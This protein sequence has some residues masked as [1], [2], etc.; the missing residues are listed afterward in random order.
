M[1][2]SSGLI[3]LRRQDVFYNMFETYNRLRLIIFKVNTANLTDIYKQRIN[4][5]WPG[6]INTV[7]GLAKPSIFKNYRLQISCLKLNMIY[8]THSACFNYAINDFQRKSGRISFTSVWELVKFFFV[9]GAIVFLLHI[10]SRFFVVVVV[11]C[12]TSL[13]SFTAVLTPRT[14]VESVWDVTVYRSKIENEYVSKRIDR[15]FIFCRFHPL[16]FEPVGS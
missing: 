1:R 9:F 16:S 11:L 13:V 14:S 6:G 4:T 8:Q 3:Y 12:L 2:L 10:V 15:I 7:L 5:T